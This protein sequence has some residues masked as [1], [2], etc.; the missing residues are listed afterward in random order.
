MNR[1]IIFNNLSYLKWLAE[2]N[3]EGKPMEKF[4]YQFDYGN[5]LFIEKEFDNLNDATDYIFAYQDQI[6]TTL[7][8]ESPNENTT[9][10]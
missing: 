3:K 4:W 8:I 1:E 2:N 10:T 9:N 6:V 5:G 7:R